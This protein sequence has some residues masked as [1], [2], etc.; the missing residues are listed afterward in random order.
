MDIDNFKYLLAGMFNEGSDVEERF[1]NEQT[2]ELLSLVKE[3]LDCRLD[4]V[5]G[6]RCAVWRKPDSGKFFG[7]VMSV[8]KAILGLD[9]DGVY[10]AVILQANEKTAKELEEKY[11]FYRELN[12]SGR[13]QLTVFLDG[14]V[15]TEEIMEYVE[16][17]YMSV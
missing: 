15:P 5:L 13:K 3:K 8:S 16:Q 11:S 17:S 4:Y 7:A 2:K 1:E 6:M 12:M 14:T 10:E 9:D